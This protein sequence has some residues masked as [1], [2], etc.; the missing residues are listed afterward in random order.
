MDFYR[1]RRVASSAGGDKVCRTAASADLEDIV[2]LDRDVWADI[3]A[4]DNAHTWR[5][6]IDYATVLVIKD[7]GWLMGVAVAFPAGGVEGIY[8]LHKIFV[9]KEVRRQRFGTHLLTT[10][11][12]SLRVQTQRLPVRQGA[13]PRVRLT[14]S[15]HNVEAKKLY[16]NFGFDTLWTETDYYGP[17]EARTIMQKLLI[18]TS[19]SEKETPV[20]PEKML[21]K[22][23]APS[24]YCSGS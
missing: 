11:L 22:V 2:E 21:P 3:H 6:W 13:S 5:L 17:G 9:R 10:A 24:R 14:V 4:I 15:P 19:D 16:T 23:V 20:F 8:L 12:H 7:R 1:I 18:P